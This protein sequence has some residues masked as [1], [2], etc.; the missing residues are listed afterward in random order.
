MKERDKTTF[1]ILVVIIIFAIGALIGGYAN[2]VNNFK[3]LSEAND[4]KREVI[5]AYEVYYDA[6]EAVINDDA[7]TIDY[8][9]RAKERLDSLYRLEE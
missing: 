4:Y 9:S 7:I 1:I 6:A 3:W 8:Y 5:E 2:C